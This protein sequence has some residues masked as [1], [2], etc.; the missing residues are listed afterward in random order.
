MAHEYLIFIMERPSDFD[1][2]TREQEAVLDE[3]HRAFVK[4]V[5]DA[6]GAIIDGAPLENP[7][8][9]DRFTPQPDGTVLRTDGPFAESKEVVLGYY[10]IR[11][12]NDEQAQEFAT[13]CPTA[14]YVDLRRVYAPGESITERS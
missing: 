13:W 10:R 3:R 5:E 4:R 7:E 9:L 12:A 6:G 14:R 2:F 1:G 8:P 11:A